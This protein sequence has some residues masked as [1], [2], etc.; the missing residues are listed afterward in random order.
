MEGEGVQSLDENL[1]NGSR[2]RFKWKKT[3]RLVVSGIKGAGLLMCFIYVCLQL[4]SSPAKKPPI[5][6]LKVPVTGCEN[7]RLFISLYN[8]EHQIMEVQNNSVF[9]NCDGLYA[10][11]LKGFFFQEVKIDLHYRNGKSPISMPMLNNGR[12]VVFT[13]VVSLAF[14]DK[15]YLTVNAPDTPC[16]HL[17]IND[18]ELIVVQLTPGY[19]APEGS[20]HSTVNQVSL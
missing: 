1:E 18:G 12:R 19:C 14:K 9:I 13:V 8:N 11:S 5:Q 20:Y 15:V 16:E 17:Q 4:S 3:L 6:R 10:V 7:G 2:P